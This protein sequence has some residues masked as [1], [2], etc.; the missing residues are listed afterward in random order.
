MIKVCNEY[1]ILQSFGNFDLETLNSANLLERMDK[2]YLLNDARLEELFTA[3][4]PFYDVLK[5]EEDICFGYKT[6]YYDTNDFKFYMEHHAG[7]TSRLKT[8]TR[9]YLNQ[10]SSFAEIKH[11][12]NK[13][14]TSKVRYQIDSDDSDPESVLANDVDVHISK[15]C[16]IYYNRYTFMN[17]ARNE[18][19]T[20]DTHLRFEN[21][22]EEIHLKHLCIA[23]LKTHSLFQSEFKGI[24]SKLKISPGSI[25]KYCIAIAYLYPEIKQNN[26][27]EKIRL[28]NKIIN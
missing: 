28:I 8:R 17:K 7:K 19:V 15:K 26:F 1:P 2:K 3:M 22:D 21:K 27:K 14:I 10:K 23:E 16:V 9:S 12:S 13:G 11:K 25:S 6:D 4:M 24:M 18:K 5:I 20:I